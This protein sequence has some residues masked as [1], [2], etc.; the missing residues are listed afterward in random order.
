MLFKTGLIKDQKSD[1]ISGFLVFLIALPLCL[2]IAK[3]SGF[4]PIAG[5]Y[6]AVIG[7][8]IVTFLSTSALTIKG[9]AAGLIAIAAGAVQELGQG[10][11]H[12][13]YVLTLAVI[14]IS[15]VLQIVLGLIKSGK[16]SDFFPASIV[17][18]MLAAIGIIII[19]KQVHFG[20]GVVPTGKEPFELLAE[21]PHSLRNWNLE[22]AL[23][24]IISLLILFLHPLIKQK[25]IKRFPAPLLVLMIA[26]P[27]GLIFDLSHVHD[28]DI[29]SLHFHI[30]PSQVLVALPSDFFSGRTF[31]DFSE[32]FSST[33]IKYVIMFALVGSIE[34]LL[35]TKAIDSLDPEHRKTNMNRDL[36]AIGIGN[37]IAGFVGGL[38]MIS[39]IVRSSSNINNGGKTRM[40]NFYHGLFLFLFAFFAAVLIQKI[41][42]AALSSML[43][44]T[45]FRLASPK[46]FKKAKDIGYDQLFLFLVTLVVT[47]TT[48]LLLGVAAGIVAKTALQITFGCKLKELFGLRWNISPANDGEKIELIGVANFIN[49]LK[50]KT[51]L[52]TIPQKTRLTLSFEKVR[53][54]DHTFIENI[55]HTQLDFVRAG[56]NI[57]LIGFENH[58]FLSKHLM[59]ARKKIIN[60][61]NN[62]DSLLS[63]RQQSFKDLS[64][65]F[66]CDFERAVRPSIIRPY[67]SPFS[68]LS[69]FKTCKKLVVCNYDR[70]NVL[71]TD[72]EINKIGDF[73]KEIDVI[74]LTIINNID[75]QMIP[76][77]FLEKEAIIRD[78]S[79]RH[80]FEA[81]K[82]D[83]MSDF[84]IYGKNEDDITTFFT[85]T[86][87]NL[88]RENN[89]SIESRRGSIM[90]HKDFE[91]I[92]GS[93]LPDI[94]EFTKKLANEIIK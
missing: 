38:P 19:S 80:D 4:P 72:L 16:L 24:G 15:G 43:I 7:G 12:K 9:P 2:G 84:D 67:L 69:K 44:Y 75:C 61:Y 40:S 51:F 21:I 92:T 8:L 55:Y 66:S 86:I 59:A 11:I 41:P 37:T 83:S 23:I 29:A 27:L 30:D 78:M 57:T 20:L 17:H 63:K 73:T 13:G 88:L 82:I 39:E 77:F 76:E 28:Y 22:V 3:A 68:I 89:Y 85:P 5:I 52:E 79:Y 34:S 25:T 62:S 71:I 42:V 10:N 65:Q 45:G 53:L 18:G 56:G 32:I 47:L 14:V 35:S 90:I 93:K 33:S 87:I 26:I 36:I 94:M 70:Y 46:E 54:I 6:T 50:F 64:V 48:D 58:N 31:P 49:F 60:P 91:R 74:T 81:I 1:I